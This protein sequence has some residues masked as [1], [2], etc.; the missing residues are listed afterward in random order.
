MLQC[1]Y[2]SEP[3][4]KQ[5]LGFPAQTAQYNDTRSPRPK[6]QLEINGNDTVA[7]L[8][9]ISSIKSPT[10][11]Q[12]VTSPR[13]P[14]PPPTTPTASAPTSIAGDSKETFEN[15]KKA[16]MA[17]GPHVRL[18]TA[19]FEQYGMPESLYTALKDIFEAIIS[20]QSRMG[21]VVPAKFME[22]LR[23]K[24]EVYRSPQH[25]DAHEFLNLLLNEVVEQVEKY[26]KSI[27]A[28]NELDPTKPTEVATQK[29]EPPA[30]TS[31][32]HQ[33]FEGTLTSETR[34]LTC[35][36]V[37]RRDEVFIDLSVDLEEHSS[38][39]SCL[40]KF[41]Q[42][43]MLCER[44][45]FHCDKCSGLQEAE[46]R[47]KIKRLPRILSLHLKRFKYAEEVQRLQKLF[48]RVVFPFHLRL[49]NTTDDCEDPDRLYELYAIIVH[50]GASPFQG[51]YVSII[52]TQDR[53]WLLFDDEL[54]LPVDAQYVRN[55]FGGDPRNSACAY[56]LFYTET[57]DEAVQRE[58]NA[59]DASDGEEYPRDVYPVNEPSPIS[60]TEAG[61][62]EGMHSIDAAAH[63]LHSPSTENTDLTALPQNPIKTSLPA[64]YKPHPIDDPFTSTTPATNTE[65]SDRVSTQAPE[66]TL[67]QTQAGE[68]EK[69]LEKP[70]SR[71]GTM[72]SGALSRFRHSSLSLKPKPRLWGKSDKADS[73]ESEEV[74]MDDHAGAHA[75]LIEEEKGEGEKE[76]YK[77]LVKTKSSRFGLGRKKS[78]NLLSRNE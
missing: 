29:V 51:H 32:V 23:A 7:G 24:Y 57:T 55:F 41:S 76:K 66:S 21:V 1:L 34:C 13:S 72:R 36:T 58:Q 45:K 31:W 75:H 49:L 10:E 8:T 12:H 16:L 27:S 6:L 56:V 22:T 60:P 53:G 43:E 61:A 69:P 20:H 71:H 73:K 9:P 46:K 63:S 15:R 48:H 59:E 68:D 70:P 35:E 25:Q 19:N 65:P 18:E 54:V 77:P 33:L 42:E 74:L 11:N 2:Y 50:L 39:T 64:Q 3:F 67:E 37:S 17:A 30:N 40:R 62:E 14:L 5:V 47:M 28:P 38:V 78:M 4:R 26:S 44:N 52:K